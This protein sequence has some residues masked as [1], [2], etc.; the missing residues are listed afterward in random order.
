[1][2]KIKADL[3]KWKSRLGLSDWDI[4]VEFKNA[5]D[6][7]Q[8]MGIAAIR[9]NIQHAAI[10]LMKTEDRQQS[11]PGEDDIELDLVHELIHVRLWAVDQDDTKGVPHACK[12][13]AI[14][15]IAKVL[16]K[17]DRQADQGER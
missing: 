14:E 4:T 9:E 10:R 3:I 13:Q 12:E 1:M 5:Q 7:R 16:I 17:T 2:D 11:E 6:M 8:N 15:W